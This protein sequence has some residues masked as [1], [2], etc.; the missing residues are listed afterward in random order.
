MRVLLTG[1][2][3]FIGR[4]LASR[5]VDEGHEVKAL[6]RK[7]SDRS[8]LPQSVEL[9]EGDLLDVEQLEAATKGVDAVMH[10]AAYFDFYPS[11]VPL[12]YR[13]NVDGTR[14]LMNACVGT[15]VER[16]IYC[17]TTEVIGPV[18]SPP[19][20]EESEL[21][22]AFD[23]SK[24]KVMAEAL[25]R[26]ITSDTGLA[27]VILRPTGVMGEGDLY[28]AYE[29]IKALND[30]EVP[31]LPG[32]GE[33]HIMY[34]HVDDIV[35]GFAKAL[36]SEGALNTTMILCPDA[37]MKY[38]ELVEFVCETLGVKAPK[39]SVPTSL[40]KIGIG[41][42]SPIKN[43]HRTTFLW[44]MQT[45][46]SMDEDRWYS[47]ERAKRVLGWSPKLTMQEGIKRSIEWYYANGHLVR[48][49]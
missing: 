24:S 10:L 29:L 45:V 4:R 8:G 33:K 47:N 39:R 3:G 11:D 17:S 20:N 6:V 28:T 9:R 25:V 38:K 23:Y 32:D 2:T 30:G 41:L 49:K 19:G 16:F 42:M 48:R 40:A 37:P 1:A 43:R 14:N 46:Q 15:D 22:P 31:I 34:T 35:D 12:L 5:L 27:H 13:V 36:T 26:E 18:R 21:R 44:H 7:T